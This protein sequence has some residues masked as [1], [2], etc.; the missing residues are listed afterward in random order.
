VALNRTFL[1]APGN[2]PRRVEKALAL[3]A[4]AVILDLEDAV[5]PQAKAEARAQVARWLTPQRAVVIR[6]NAPSTVWFAEDLALCAMAG[7]AAVMVPKAEHVAD[8]DRIATVAVGRAILPL[9]ET[10]AGFDNA[11]AL[12]AAD[13]VQ[14]L[15]FGSIDFQADL[16]IAGEDD[17]LL[18]FRSQL[19]LVSRLADRA[20]PVDGVS[21]ALDEPDV[22]ERDTARARRLGFGAKLCIHPR[23][24]E[25]VNRGFSP[26]EDELAWARRVIEAAARARGA[27]VALDGKMVDRP[28]I[29]R[30]QAM[31]DEA[32]SRRKPPA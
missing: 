5:A 1:F 32:E 15:V 9:I 28:V 16:G 19:V 30:A 23:Q 12:A 24:V 29:L 8:L 13:S 3:G 31:V 2:H 21:T 20:A 26:T 14:R 10:A 27:A 22:L 17:A 25:A 7:V 4:D 18:Y 11:R 6:I